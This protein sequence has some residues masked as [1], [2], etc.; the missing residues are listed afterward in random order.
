L[1]RF[2]KH[3]FSKTKWQIISKGDDKLSKLRQITKGVIVIGL[4]ILIGLLIFPQFQE[5]DAQ[6]STRQILQDLENQGITNCEVWV[7]NEFLYKPVRIGLIHEAG[8]QTVSISSQDPESQVSWDGTKESF[9]MVTDSA[10]RHS[11]QVILDYDFKHEEPRQ[12]Y[13]QVFAE[14]NVLMMEGNWQHEGFTFCKIIDFWTVDAPTFLTPEEIT[15]INNKFNSEFRAE[16][17]EQNTTVE[18]G[19]LVISIIVLVVG[20]LITLFFMVIIIAMR[21]MAN[22][23]KRPAKKLNEMV[24]KVRKLSDVLRLQTQYNMTTD[25]DMKEKLIQKVENSLRDLSIMTVGTMQKVELES[26]FPKAKS[27]V[28]NQTKNTD[29]TI[30]HVVDEEQQKI[31]EQAYEESLGVFKHNIGKQETTFADVAQEIEEPKKESEEDTIEIDIKDIKPCVYCGKSP[32]FY[33]QDCRGMFCKEHES[34]KC[35]DTEKKSL[36]KTDLISSLTEKIIKSVMEKKDSVVNSDDAI[37]KL[38]DDGKSKFDVKCKLINE[39]MKIPYR[40]AREIYDDLNKQFDKNKTFPK[41]LRIEALMERL[42]K[43]DK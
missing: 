2:Q 24:E 38:L 25:K 30:V 14:S 28:P 35:K 26:A 22:V 18:N 20:I 1:G 15:E 41:S 13:F 19:L 4:G 39:F 8:D 5:A 34:H 11:V 43:S 9:R 7:I 3:T 23:S 40:E 33:C 32:D 10:G 12:V 29:S 36:K 37:Q 17:A 21:G 6:A 16:V 31:N 42:V 27:L